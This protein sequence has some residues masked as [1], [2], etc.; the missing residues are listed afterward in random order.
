[1]RDLR[2]TGPDELVWDPDRSVGD[3]ALYRGT[4]SNP[5]DPS[6]GSCRLPN[7]V[8]PFTVEDTTPVSGEVLFYL[9]TARNRLREES[10][11]GRASN[12]VERAN[13]FPCP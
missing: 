11:K 6:Y 7:P 5:F 12:D 4:V 9:V 3:Y 2:F 1:V 13:P 8:E 10:T